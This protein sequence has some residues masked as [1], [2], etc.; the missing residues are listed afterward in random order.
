MT[1]EN[2]MLSVARAEIGYLEKA[3]NRNLDGKTD[4]VGSGNWTKYARDLDKLGFFHAPKNGLAWCAVF[5]AWCFTQ[6]FGMETALKLLC[7]P[8]GGYGASCTEVRR[9]YREAGRYFKTAPQPGDQI[10]FTKHGGKECNHTG[11]VEWVADGVIHTIEGNTGVTSGVVENGGCVWRKEYPVGY[12]KIDGYGRPNWSIVQEEDEEM[13][14]ETFYSMFKEAMS[15]Y[16]TEL[17][18]N[19]SSG[20]SEKARQF[21]VE[22]GIFAGGGTGPDGEP[23]Y[24]W[25]DL[26]TREQAAVILYRFAVENGLA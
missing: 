24:M 6:T 25:E 23:N 11:I 21:V 8:K 19:D 7:Q 5:V 17:R 15:Q 20:W 4:N 1:P 26:L 16:R 12:A 3:S 9:Y 2:R 14:K 10:L 18:D 22:K 13:D